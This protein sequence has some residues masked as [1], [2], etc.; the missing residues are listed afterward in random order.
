MAAVL[1][2]AIVALVH[3]FSNV[4]LRPTSLP[5]ANAQVALTSI[6]AVAAG[7][8]VVYVLP[9][10]DLGLSF[11]FFSFDLSDRG[12]CIGAQS[13]PWWPRRVLDG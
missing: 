8:T 7:S 6:D 2:F 13:R 1:C 11:H 3:E 5:L 4:S 12:D 9:P 10:G